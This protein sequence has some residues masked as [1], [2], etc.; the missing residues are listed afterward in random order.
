MAPNVASVRMRLKDDWELGKLSRRFLGPSKASKLTF[1]T[2]DRLQLHFYW[3]T[4]A[5]NGGRVPAA[6]IT[7]LL[8]ATPNLKSLEL[9]EFPHLGPQ[10]LSLPHGLTSLVLIDTHVTGPALEHIGNTCFGL[11]RLCVYSYENG[12]GDPEN[13]SLA[14]HRLTLLSKTTIA[15]RLQT[16]VLSSTVLSPGPLAAIEKF[17][18]LKVLGIRYA[19]QG[20]NAFEKEQKNDLLVNLVKNCHNLRGLLVAG[21]FRIKSKAMTQFATAVSKRQFPNLRQ[22]KLVCRSEFWNDLNSVVRAPIEELCRAG[23]AE[24]VLGIHKYEGTAQLVEEMEEAC[25]GRR[26]EDTEE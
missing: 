20:G 13:S 5:V 11:K 6:S 12:L 14:A 19:F 23:N 18:A 9:R 8:A 3:S 26:D 2:L 4:G 22:V 25:T 17:S 24:L 7:A 15:S 1:P 21:A 16:L 10:H